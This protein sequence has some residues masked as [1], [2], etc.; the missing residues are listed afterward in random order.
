MQG[1]LPLSASAAGNSN[2]PFHH[3]QNPK[4]L[5]RLCPW[6]RLAGLGLTALLLGPGKVFK[7]VWHPWQRAQLCGTAGAKRQGRL[8]QQR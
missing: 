3:N 6:S 2:N 4:G 8:Q 7:G 5:N 1:E